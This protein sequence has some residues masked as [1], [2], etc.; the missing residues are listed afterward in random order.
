MRFAGG[1]GGDRHDG[2]PRTHP[3]P[4]SAPTADLAEM[5]P[6]SPRRAACRMPGGGHLV[7]AIADL[8]NHGHAVDWAR[9]SRAPSPPVDLPTQAFQHERFWLDPIRAAARRP[10]SHPLLGAAVDLPDTGGTLFVGDLDVDEVPWLTEHTILGSRLLPGTALLELAVAAGERLDVPVVDE[11]TM[12]APVAVTG[13]VHVQVSV[14]AL[15]DDRRTI[16][17]HV[18]T[19]DGSW[20]RAADGVLT[21]SVQ[22]ARAVHW[23]ADHWPA[24]LEPV[25]WTATT[26]AP[27][28]PGSTTARPSRGSRRS[29]AGG[30]RSSRRRP[31]RTGPTPTPCTPRCSTRPSVR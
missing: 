26:T 17:V 15:E 5:K 28:S 27:H 30:P 25:P 9:S 6:W 2:L 12:L 11:L 29:G 22:P 18:R 16:S 3:T 10:A 20:V 23:P 21:T 19:G 24:D 8:H 31:C 4:R 7:G 1:P 13:T 14:A